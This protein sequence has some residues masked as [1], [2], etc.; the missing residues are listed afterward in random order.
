MLPFWLA[1]EQVAVAP[2]SH[3]QAGYAAEAM[4]ALEHAGLRAVRFTEAETLSRRI[5]AAHEAAVPV[6]AILGRREQE[7]RT[8]TLRERDGTQSVL[9]LAETVAALSMR[10]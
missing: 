3:D 4:E 2:I 10:R 7:N 5:L 6:I 1:P 9:P 8:L